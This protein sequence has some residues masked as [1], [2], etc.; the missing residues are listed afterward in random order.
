[1]QSPIPAPTI[2]FALFSCRSASRR[3]FATFCSIVVRFSF[4]QYRPLRPHELPPLARASRS[5][6]SLPLNRSGQ[7]VL[8]ILHTISLSLPAG[9]SS[10]SR[11]VQFTIVS[12]CSSPKLSLAIAQVVTYGRNP[13]AQVTLQANPA[14]CRLSHLSPRK[15]FYRPSLKFGIMQPSGCTAMQP[16]A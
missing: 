2:N 12:G 3:Q 4:G 14:V 7:A 15:G 5:R 11:F 6:A 13:V 10:P 1:M 9:H 8:T 16:Q